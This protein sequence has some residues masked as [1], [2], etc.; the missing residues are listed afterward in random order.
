MTAWISPTLPNFFR[1]REESA[2]FGLLTMSTIGHSLQKMLF[3]LAKFESTR[4]VF[5]DS[6]CVQMPRPFDPN[7]EAIW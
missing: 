7:D 1:W 6:G 4:S 5:D 3:Q 2:V